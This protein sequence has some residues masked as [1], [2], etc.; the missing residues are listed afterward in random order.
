MLL[1]RVDRRETGPLSLGHPAARG[2]RIRAPLGRSSSPCFLRCGRSTPSRPIRSSSKRPDRFEPAHDLVGGRID[3]VHHGFVELGHPYLPVDELG[4]EGSETRIDG[5][6]R[7]VGVGIDPVDPA[8]WGS[9]HPHG[10]VG[11]ADISGTG[12]LDLGPASV[13]SPSELD[14]RAAGGSSPP[15]SQAVPNRTSASTTQGATELR[16]FPPSVALLHAS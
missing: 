2:Q 1:R 13:T 6:D 5:G 14:G 4:T 3:D 9:A 8:R 10:V 7:F 11:P 16:M 15:P 12:G